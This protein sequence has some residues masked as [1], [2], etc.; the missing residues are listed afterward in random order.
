MINE[1]KSED[2]FQNLKEGFSEFGKKVSSLMDD[3]LGS[4][5]S[6]GDVQVRTDIYTANGQYVIELE[7]A[8]VQKEHVSIQIHEGVLAVKGQK[9]YPEE[10]RERSYEKKERQ[11]GSFLRTFTLPLDVELE[12]IKAKYDSGILI[13]RLNR[14]QAKP[15]DTDTDSDVTIE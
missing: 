1:N 9:D 12:N 2:M 14:P 10:V 4:E 11:Y 15:A 8:G 3:V 5:G 6:S 7:L 13:I